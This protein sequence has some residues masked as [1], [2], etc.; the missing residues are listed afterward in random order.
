MGA[1]L[2]T[3]SAH[4]VWA[5]DAP[6]APVLSTYPNETPAQHA[7]RMKWFH[8]ARFG[9]FIH[10]G[11]YSVPAGVYKDKRYS[12]GA[13]WIKEFAKIPGSEYRAYGPL[14]TA[15]E[16][17]PEAWVKLA[18]D[19]GMKYI[20]ITTKHHEGFA[21]FDSK[22][23]TWDAVDEGGAHRDLLRPLVEAARRE[24]IKIGFYYSQA[25]DWMHPGGSGASFDPDHKGD[26][27]AYLKD[28]AL[29]QVK[30][31]LTNYGPIDVFWWDTAYG[32]NRERARPFADLLATQPAI[33]SNNRLGGDYRGDTETPEGFIPGKQPDRD[34]EVCMNINNT[35]GYSAVGKDFKSSQTLIRNLVDIASKGGNYLLNVGPTKEGNIPQA[36]IDR[37]KTVGAWMKTNGDSI[38]ATNASPLGRLSWGRAT[39]KQANGQTTLYLHVFNWP[40]S[41]K[42]RVPGLLDLPTSARVLLGNA[43][44]K[45]VSATNGIILTLPKTAPDPD[46]STLVLQFKG[47]PRAIILPASPD[48]DGI[49]RLPVSDAEISGSNLKAGENLGWW[50]NPDD[51]ATWKANL[52]K[53]GT[54]EISADLSATEDTNIEFKVGNQT[55]R[56]AVAPT[57]NYDKYKPTILGRMTLP[58]GPQ[59]FELH[60][61]KENWHPAN[62]KNLQIKAISP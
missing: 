7:A 9:M 30:E 43:K 17:D 56:F 15:G 12:F 2:L 11:A 39:Q 36:E 54:Y 24:G 49:L 29:P 62:L 33:I 10:W 21:L 58:A 1:T 40:A 32:M 60:A 6:E 13:E 20:V 3:S 61:V 47:T 25:Q 48:A 51:Y 46:S 14:F 8:E 44:I 5:Q 26:M 35:W 53:P 22:V 50:T 38:Y 45:S 55:L 42:L 4:R 27:D 28:I 37:L 18:K 16:Y 19:A 23:T 57:G 31:L 34:F 52:D 41:G 59:S